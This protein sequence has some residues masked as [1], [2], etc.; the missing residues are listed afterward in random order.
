MTTQVFRLVQ[1]TKFQPVFEWSVQARV[2][3]IH[4]DG[5]SLIAQPGQLVTYLGA[6]DFYKGEP[7]QQHLFQLSHGEFGALD[8]PPDERFAAET[9]PEIANLVQRIKT[10]PQFLAEYGLDLDKVSK[11]RPF[12][13]IVCPMCGGTAFTTMDLASVWCDNCNTR[14]ETRYTAGDPGV[15]V[16][17]HLEHYSPLEARIVAPKSLMLTLV[18]KDFGFSNHPEG[19]CGDYCCNTAGG[20]AKGYYRTPAGLREGIG[21]C[22]LEV[23]EWHL[24]GVPEDP[25]RNRGNYIPAVAPD[26]QGKHTRI[27]LDRWLYSL[28]YLGTEGMPPLHLLAQGEKTGDSE[29]WFLAGGLPQE[30]GE[31]RGWYPLWWKARPVLEGNYLK[32][33]LITDHTLCPHCLKPAHDP[34]ISHDYCNWDALGWNPELPLAGLYEL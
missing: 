30:P 26:S 13:M 15:V 2:A 3:L 14:F 12:A 23:H 21:P 28:K 22:G 6:R 11:L 18:L 17:A 9:D 19:S 31:K 32:S 7:Q 20:R 24:Y 25:R 29:R 27:N 1:E 8:S 5:Q 4:V 34:E 16:D 33:W 10:L